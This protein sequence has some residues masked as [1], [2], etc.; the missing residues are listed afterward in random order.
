MGP[1]EIRSTCIATDLHGMR[2]KYWW[3]AQECYSKEL[4]NAK[5]FD[6]KTWTTKGINVIWTTF[7]DVWNARNTHLHMEWE[8]ATN[9]VL[10]KQVRKAFALKHSIFQSNHLLFQTTLPE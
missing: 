6:C 9:N 7:V 4:L 5:F 8:S 10:D 3:L 1:N 2:P